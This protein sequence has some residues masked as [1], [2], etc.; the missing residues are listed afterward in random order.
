MIKDHAELTLGMVCGTN[1][2]Y[3]FV[4]DGTLQQRKINVG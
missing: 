1:N 2:Y 3:E 4:V